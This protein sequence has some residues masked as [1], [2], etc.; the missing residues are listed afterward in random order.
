MG[1]MTRRRWTTLAAPTPHQRLALAPRGRFTPLMKCQ[2]ATAIEA[3]RSVGLERG[4][5]AD[6]TER[7]ALELRQA[8]WRY[9][10]EHCDGA[11]ADEIA[12]ALGRDRLAVRPRVSELVR[13]Q[14]VR[15][16]GRRR[17]NASGRLA[18]VWIADRL[19]QGNG[20]TR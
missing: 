10:I 1:A 5:D 9:L 2:P 13:M 16:S 12:A 15:A 14:R 19:E 7:E 20:G 8:V 6:M 17:A 4:G 11:T 18:I 3:A